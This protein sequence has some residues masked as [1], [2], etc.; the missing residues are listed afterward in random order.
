MGFKK[1]KPK[2]LVAFSF[3]QRPIE[4]SPCNKRLAK[5]VERIMREES[6]LI[7]VVAQWEVS[8]GLETLEPILT[9]KKHRQSDCY[10]DCD[11]VTAQAVPLFRELGITEVIVV[12]NPFLHLMRCKEVVREAGFVP[13]KRRVGWIGFDRKSLQWW[14]KGPLEL[15]FYSVL[16]KLIGWKGR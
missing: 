8:L 12:G 6:G 4:P 9:V 16:Q 13:V 1:A 15:F 7:V 5:A 11:E 14:T 3:A 2:G 10:L